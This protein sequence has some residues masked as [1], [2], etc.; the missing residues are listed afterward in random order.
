MR[1]LPKAEPND[2][3]YVDYDTDTGLYCVFGSNTGHAYSSWASKEQADEAL[4]R[5]MP[6]RIEFCLYTPGQSDYW[7]EFK[8]QAELFA[9]MNAN[10]PGYQYDAKTSNPARAFYR[11]GELLVVVTGM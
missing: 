9:W 4:A 1:T 6:K 11:S 5:E 2:P 7:G 8:T 10:V 3:K